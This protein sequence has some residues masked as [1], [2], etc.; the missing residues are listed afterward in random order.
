MKSLVDTDEATVTALFSAVYLGSSL[1]RLDLINVKHMSAPEPFAALLESLVK[2]PDLKHLN[3][4][5]NFLDQR[6]LADVVEAM[7]STR[8]ITFNLA[9]NSMK[10]IYSEGNSRKSKVGRKLVKACRAFYQS[11]SFML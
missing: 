2:L 11:I 4:A 9:D 10:P 8:L 1:Q 5:S 6:Q 7:A 3:L